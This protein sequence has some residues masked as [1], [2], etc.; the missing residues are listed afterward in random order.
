MVQ[1]W[2]ASIH[3]S[4]G[5]TDQE[6]NRLI[7]RATSLDRGLRGDYNL[8]QS[9]VKGVNRYWV[10]IHKKFSIPF[11]CIVFVL[12]GAPVGIMARRGGFVVATSL[13]LG[14]FMVYWALLIAGE[15]LGDRGLL[16][17][18][19]A[20][21]SPNIILIALGVFLLNQIRNEFRVWRLDILDIFRRKQLQDET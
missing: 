1:R 6:A 20:M 9:Y 13:S 14:F 19:L 18:F 11:A 21:W 10:E 12:V 8:I 16:S 3:D 7:R 15:E 4:A 5:L 17:P 2:S